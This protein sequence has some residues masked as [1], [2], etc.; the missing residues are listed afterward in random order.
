MVQLPPGLVHAS[1]NP[2]TTRVDIKVLIRLYESRNDDEFRRVIPWFIAN[3]LK[4]D[5]RSVN[6]SLQHLEELGYVER[7]ER[8]GSGN[9]EYRLTMPANGDHSPPPLMGAA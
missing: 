8:C 9:F 6:R 1:R 4:V 2:D 5:V 7:G 3:L